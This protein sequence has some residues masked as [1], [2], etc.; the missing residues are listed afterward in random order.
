VKFTEVASRMTGFSS[1]IFGVSWQPP[2]PDVTIARRMI[3]F[4]EDRRV[5][6]EP[7]EVKVPHLCISSITGIRDFLTELIA[8]H[9][10]SKDL[11]ISLRSMRAA[12]RKFMAIVSSIPPSDITMNN[13]DFNQALGELRG[14]IGI[15]VGL[16]AMK[17][18]LD[19]EDDLASILPTED[20]EA[21]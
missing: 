19:V 17:Y 18:R 8:D 6:Y 5:L 15:H 16:L 10:G 9:A 21:D 4:L 1:P 2:T 3:A 20:L 11:E 7:Y 12:C 14:V 13:R